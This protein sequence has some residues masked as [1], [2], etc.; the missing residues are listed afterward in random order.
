MG[1]EPVS[2]HIRWVPDRELERLHIVESKITYC[3]GPLEPMKEARLVLLTLPALA[4]NIAWSWI[5]TRDERAKDDFSADM[6]LV[7]ERIIDLDFA[8]EEA[9]PL[10]VE[11][12]VHIM[13]KDFWIPFT[14]AC[15]HAVARFAQ[16]AAPIPNIAGVSSQP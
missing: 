2:I 12:N 14:K 9:G 5:N 10:S 7:L 16:C 15:P 3:E 13:G 6:F 8:Q 11:E 4:D 1:A